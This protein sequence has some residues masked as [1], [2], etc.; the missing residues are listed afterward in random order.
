MYADA[1]NSQPLSFTVGDGVMVNDA[2]VVSADVV[3]SN[4]LI[5]VIDKVLTPSDTP[6]DIPRAAQCTGTH[7]S[8]VTAVI[9]AELLE[10]LQGPVLSPYSLQPTKHSLM[11]A[12]IS[13]QWIHPKV[14]L[15]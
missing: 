7:D 1:A 15:H 10:T 6:R 11:Q 2:N 9:Q 4:G 3:T 5:H 14:R 8:L 13:L 12:S